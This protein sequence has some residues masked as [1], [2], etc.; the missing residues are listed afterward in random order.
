[1]VST[2]SGRG[3]DIGASDVGRRDAWRFPHFTAKIGPAVSL[4]NDSFRSGGKPVGFATKLAWWRALQAS[5][6]LR[7]VIN[8]DLERN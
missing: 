8:S 3:A 4:S 6:R 7:H 2:R 5:F 1:V